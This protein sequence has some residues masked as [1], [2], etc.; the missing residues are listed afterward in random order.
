MGLNFMFFS[1]YLRKLKILL[2]VKYFWVF[3]LFGL[4]FSSVLA[5]NCA[6]QL[7]PGGGDED[8]I[9][10]EI[11]SQI[12]ASNT[13]NFRGNT[14][15]FEFDEYV[16]RRSFQDAF[17]ISP[18]I[19]GEISYNWSGKEVEVVF[20][21]PL[22][23]VN[24]NK[25]FVFTLNTTLKDIHGNSLGQPLIFAV[26]TGPQIDKASITGKIINTNKNV[27]S[28]LAYS[29]NGNEVSY[30][31]IKKVA[32]YITETSIEGDYNLMNMAPGLYR[33]IAIKDD[34]K[35]YL[36]SEGIEDY[37][38][39]SRDIKIND[40]DKISNISFYM[41]TRTGTD[42]SLIEWKNFARDTLNIVHS[43]IPDNSV[44]AP[45]D[46]GITFF[47]NR[48]KPEREYLGN[49]FRLTDAANNTERVVFTWKNDSLVQVYPVNN[50]KPGTMYK[51]SFPLKL[52]ADTLYNYSLRFRTVTAN[53]YGNVKGVVR[54]SIAYDNNIQS[55]PLIMK[56]ETTNNTAP[57]MSYSFEVNDTTF[58]FSNIIEADYSIFT[59]IDV[60][61]N[62][63]F[64]LG[65][66]YPFQF[67]EPFYT[68]PSTV[69]IKGGW[70]VENVVIN[71]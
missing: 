31:P 11:I 38:V 23:K 35:N 2:K 71:F 20:E 24:D 63:I 45:L 6:N 1:L 49:N 40:T 10:P 66:V 62:G 52:A 19:T 7:P 43:S 12:P 58:S 56:F 68:Y 50:F 70:V 42:S 44:N 33:V 46:Q 3:W 26:S 64:D 67:S 47:F 9:P 36:Y 37:G 21:R 25:T 28:V 53:S 32:D 22:Y 4:I 8:K 14:L 41:N 30:D 39:L 60:N 29:L 27:I 18:P 55:A 54:R 59:F 16:D 48:F 15:H 65:S 51:A 5:T 13:L 34:D 61:K 69:G 17:R 57:V